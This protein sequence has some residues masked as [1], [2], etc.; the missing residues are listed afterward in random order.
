MRSHSKIRMVGFGWYLTGTSIFACLAGVRIGDPLST[1]AVSDMPDRPHA[2]HRAL[3]K[4][5]PVS[6][7]RPSGDHRAHLTLSNRPPRLTA[8]TP[9]H[10]SL[11]ARSLPQ[12]D[13]EDTS[14]GR[15][16]VLACTDRAAVPPCATSLHPHSVP[17]PHPPTHG[18][19]TGAIFSSQ[20]SP[21]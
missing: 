21:H 18:L 12:L 5:A 11:T 19:V 6:D 17:I 1:E 7:R 13:A 10:R 2:L 8:S 16:P 3:L 20:T 4:H 14:R 9:S 15:A